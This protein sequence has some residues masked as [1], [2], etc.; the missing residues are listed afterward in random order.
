MAYFW[1]DMQRSMT[2]R[3]LNG[4]LLAG[5]LILLR[6]DLYAQSFLVPSDT[7]SQSRFYTIAASGALIYGSTV[8]GLNQ[9][10]YKDFAKTSFHFFDDRGE[11]LNMDKAGHIFTT[12]FESEI[13]YQGA[14]WTG[15]KERNAIW[16]GA[17]LGLFYQSTVEIFDAYSS[18]WGFSVAD[19]LYNVVGATLFASQQ[20]AWSEQRVRFKISSWPKQY[21]SSPIQSTSGD[22]ASSLKKRAN[23]LFGTGF[24]ERYLKDYNAQTIWLSINPKSFFPLL[25]FPVWLNISVGYGSENLYG[26]FSNSWMEGTHSFS[27]DKKQFPRSTQWFLAPDIDFK[28]IKTNNPL[29]K[30]VFSVLNIFK[31]P[32]PTLEYKSDGKLKWHWIFL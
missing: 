22:F 4:F 16:L 32:S 7:F 31:V 30:T 18:R 13:S 15:M 21:S 28:K 10:W 29:L 3:C 27:L 9:A 8:V 14:K 23:N 20:A 5:L 24:F 26:G 6:P 1:P 12:Y 19:M 25:N 2:H 11:W 17:G